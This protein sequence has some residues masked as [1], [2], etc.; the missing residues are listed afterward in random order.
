MGELNPGTQRAESLARLDAQTWDLVVIGGGISGAGVA[1]QAA[2][3]GWRVLLIEQRDFAW[4]TSSR[5]SKLVHGGLRYLKEGDIKTTLHSVR[6]RERLMREAPELIEPQSFLF[7]HCVGRK[8]G[9]RLFQTG[10]MIYDLMAGLR[11]HFWAD[12]ATTQALAPGLAP[13][14]MR[15]ALVFQDAKTDDARLVWRVLMEAQRAGARVLNYV[16]AQGLQLDAGRVSG[17][18]LQDEL[19]GQS[20]QVRTQAVVNATGAWADRLRAAVGGKPML[21]PLR[22]SHLV[23]PFWRLPVAQSI[24]LMHPRD[25]RPV[26][27]Y[28]WEGATLIGTTDL[29]HRADLDVEASITAQEVDYLIEAVNDQFPEQTL[30]PAE[31]SACYAGVRPVVDDGSGTASQAARDHVVLDESGLIT[32]TGGK[33]T[34]FRLMAQDALALAAPHVG[35]SFARDD[36]VMF[37]SVGALNPGWSASVRHRLAARYGYRAGEL[38]RHASEADLQTIPGTHTLWLELIVAAQHEAVVHL[39]DLLLRRTRLGILLPRGGLDHLARIRSLCE[40]HLNWNDAQWQTEMARYR[41]L[42]AAHYQLPPSIIL[43]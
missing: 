43:N 26:F 38:S 35:K 15:G 10:L 30:K 19:T 34:T 41:T 17:L 29:D 3:R 23:V 9:R 25:G 24:S 31:V 40:P 2:R 12:L 1:Q 20:Y 37:T 8:P 14:K 28:P 32:L 5:S 18:T 22:G 6:E 42:I 21:R 27:F 16:A 4:G 33:L 11:S 13:P 7:A 39:D 36:A